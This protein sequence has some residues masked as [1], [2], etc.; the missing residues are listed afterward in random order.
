MN[1]YYDDKTESNIYIKGVVATDKY[2]KE[3]REK[4]FGILTVVKMISVEVDNKYP[5]QYKIDTMLDQIKCIV[6]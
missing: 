1:H 3:C 6:E 5:L 4:L 2:R